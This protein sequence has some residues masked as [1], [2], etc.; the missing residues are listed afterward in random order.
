MTNRHQDQAT[1]II[2]AFKD[3]LDED[4]CQQISDEKFNV[5]ALMIK[6]AMGEEL[7]VA[8]ELIEDVVRK[9]RAESDK[10]ELGM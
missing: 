2:E 4:V 5:L 9:L 1:K 10:P 3:T 8:A 6:E 7:G